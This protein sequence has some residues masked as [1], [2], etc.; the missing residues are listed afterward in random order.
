MRTPLFLGLTRPVSFAGLPMSYVLVLAMTSVGG[1]VASAS[2]V[3]LG[4]SLVIGYA[5]LRGVA[6]RDPHLFDVA[7]VT[8]RRTPPPP[9]WFTGAGVHYH[10]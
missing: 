10:A 8:L 1:F 4:T 7:L 9:G 3:W 5:A 6:A 2:F